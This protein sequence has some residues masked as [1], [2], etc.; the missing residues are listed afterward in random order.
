[1]QNSNI[2]SDTY[3]G[4]VISKH[5]AELVIEYE[6]GQHIRCV[7]RKKI[8]AIVCGDKVTWERISTNQ[9]VVTALHSRTTLLSRPDNNG[10]I[11]PVAAN[12]TQMLIVCAIKPEFDFSLIDNY[13]VSAE[14]LKI[15]P[16]LVVNKI[17]LVNKDELK[18]VA[19]EFEYYQKLNYQ[20]YFVSVLKPKKLQPLIETLA[21]QTSILV[22]QSGVGKSSIINVLLPD[23]NL[24][25]SALHDSINLGKH[26]TSTTTLYHLPASGSIID[27][28]G[29][30]EFKLWKINLTEAA[31][32]FPEFRPYIDH[33]KFRNCAHLNEP[34][35][36]V[37]QA[38]D[39][40]A[41]TERRYQSYKRII[42]SKITN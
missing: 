15:T 25:T 27:S 18:I 21:A 14:L 42:N 16:V 30:R 35:C 17:D 34:G 33:C 12:I 2:T 5:G 6:N 8:S 26:T 31:W 39:N 24:K 40:K 3:N 11:K 13:L 9:G 4:L 41:I 22:G 23:L 1:M 29:V 7:P 28:P 38:L 37:K 19:D 32:S 10:V 36:A 20:L